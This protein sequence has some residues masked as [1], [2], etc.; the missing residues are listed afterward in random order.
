MIVAMQIIVR[1]NKRILA[2]KKLKAGSRIQAQNS[3]RRCQRRRAAQESSYSGG[4]SIRGRTTH[5]G[6]CWLLVQRPVE[7]ILEDGVRVLVLVAVAPKPWLM[8][9][10]WML[11]VDG[12]KVDVFPNIFHG[13]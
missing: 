7:K 6:Y 13:D 2:I 3:F 12:T 11:A 1:G 8:V 9:A 5:G 4:S 10:L